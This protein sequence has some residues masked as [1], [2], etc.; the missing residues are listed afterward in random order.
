MK[1]LTPTLQATKRDRIGSRYSR[2]IRETGG[3]PAIIYGHGEE[4][5]P[6]TINAKIALRH[7]HSGEKVFQLALEGTNAK[8][9][10]YILLKDLQFDHLGTNIVHCDFARVDLTERVNVRVPI[11]F[12]GEAEG[13]KSVGAI[14]MHPLETIELECLL[15]N[16]P[17]YIEIDVTSMQVGSILHASDVK[18]PLPTMVLLTDPHAIVAQIVVQGEQAATG[19][20]AEVAKGSEPE[21]VARKPK[22]DAD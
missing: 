8:T 6:I 13:L 12:I 4:P 19:E 3:L 11:H 7:F 20:A 15:T 14:M 17:D 22:A 9:A 16:L 18:L 1:G 21:V 10:E 5:L 2:R